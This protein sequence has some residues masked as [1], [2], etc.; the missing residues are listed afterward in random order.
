VE[1]ELYADTRYHSPEKRHHQ[2]RSRTG[3]RHDRHVTLGMTEILPGNRHRLGPSE[4]KPA[5]QQQQSRDQY[6][7]YR[8]DMFQGIESQA[9]E[10]LCRGITELLGHPPMG[11]FVNRNGKK[12]RQN[13]DGNQLRGA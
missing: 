7:A 4:D 9:A 12:Q 11:N 10:S 5:E 1:T 8:V 2:V 6:R 3:S 13:C